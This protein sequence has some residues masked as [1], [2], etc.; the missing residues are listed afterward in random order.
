MSFITGKQLPR[1]TFLR[2]V[3][4]TVA[5]PFLDA[6][7][8]ARPGA[9]RRPAERD[10][11]GLHRGG[12][13]P[14]RAAT[15]GAPRRTCAR[16]RRPAATSS[17][18]PTARSRSLEA[19]PRLPDHRQQHRRAHGRGVRAA[20][21]RR[22]PLPLERGVP[23]AVAPEADAGLGHLVG[24]SIDQLYAQKFGQATPMPSMQFCI[25]NLDQAG[26][27]TYNYS[28]AYTDSISWA[29][30]NEPL[31][32]IRDPRVAFDM[33]FG[34]GGT[35]RGPRRAPPAPAAASSTGLP[36]RSPTCASDLGPSDRARLDKYLD[37]I[38]EIERRIQAIEAR[39]TSGETRELPGAPAGVPD[40]FSEH[41]KLMFDLQ[42]LALAVRHDPRHL[43][44]DRPR[45]AEPRVPGERL[46]PAVPPGL[47]PRRPRGPDPRVQ[48]DQQV[49]RGH[50]A[51]LPRQDE[52]HDGGDASLLDKTR[53]HLGLADGRRQRAQPPPLPAGAARQRQRHARAATCTS[54]P[55]TA[56]RWRTSC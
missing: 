12:A 14:G 36:A 29:S 6:M 37:N 35:T 7:V 32:M 4:A 31:P 20:R 26:G 43:V 38:R 3:G 39:N 8:P 47:A 49:P 48:Q 30:P 27:C 24:T 28:C 52:E 22:R 5:L 40:S 9:A 54:R 55:P 19:V 15:T 1:R 21:D 18:C 45:R 10:A 23:H 13:R 46:G 42:V 11:A 2:G 51:L 16:R 17:W 25:E 41:M 44:Q 53:D 34:A 33:L 50:A 56:R